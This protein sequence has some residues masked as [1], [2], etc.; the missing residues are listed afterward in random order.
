[1]QI[2]DQGHGGIFGNSKPAEMSDELW[3][4]IRVCWAMDP[5]QRPPMAEVEGQLGSMLEVN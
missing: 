2:A 3:E 4:I 1:M 5:S